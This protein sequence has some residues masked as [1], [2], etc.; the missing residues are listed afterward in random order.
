MLVSASIWTL[1]DDSFKAPHVQLPLKGLILGLHEI[2]WHDSVDKE[3]FVKDLESVP[4]WEPRRNMGE[5]FVFE[6]VQHFM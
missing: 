4:I 2:P 6:L 3:T 5:T 1:T